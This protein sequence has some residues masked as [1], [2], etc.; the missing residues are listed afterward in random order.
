VKSGTWPNGAVNLGQNFDY[1][2]VAG[3]GGGAWGGGGAGGYRTSYPG[4]TKLTLESVTVY[5]I[6]VGAGG[7]GAQ[8]DY[9]GRNGTDSIFSTITS[10][11]GGA[12]KLC[13]TGGSGGSGGG[14]GA[15]GGT[16]GAGN[17]PPVSPP[18]GNPGG[19]SVNSQAG[20]GGG[21]ASAAATPQSSPV[22]T[23]GAGGSGSPIATDFFGPTSASYGTSGPAPGRY[24]SGGG[25]GH[26]NPSLPGVGPGAGGAGGGGRGFG[27]P[28]VTSTTGT[29]NTGG[30]GG[31]TNLCAPN[32]PGNG[33]SGFVVV[34]GP[35]A[36][37]FTVTPGTNVVAT[38][39][40]SE[41]VAIFT[42]SGTLQIS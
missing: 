9:A 34:R 4:G 24:F 1:L 21:G 39:P 37:T 5:P 33:G 27:F 19:S 15:P 13:G 2:V 3:G 42:V 30:G 18:Q 41:K 26:G 40:A 11:G 17:T 6:T 23:G 12:G 35:S 36:R 22:G 31:G 38:G 8:P 14:T 16:G 7:A 10:A 20:A 29:V 32:G 25:G 28:S